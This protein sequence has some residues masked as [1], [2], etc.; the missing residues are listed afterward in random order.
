M[1]LIDPKKLIDEMS[2]DALM[3]DSVT[4]EHIYVQV[5]DVGDIEEAPVVDA[6]PRS[7]AEQIRWERDMA[8]AQLEEIGVGFCEMTDDVVKVVRCKDCIFYKVG[9]MALEKKYCYWARE[10]YKGVY[11]IP[12]LAMESNDYC[13][14]GVRKKVNDAAD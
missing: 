13:S 8:M 11:D 2:Y 5:V 1:E 10:I 6:I 7:V 3:H 9:D 14:H 4:G 12:M